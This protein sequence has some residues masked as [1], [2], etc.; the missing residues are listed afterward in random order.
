MSNS[1][2]NTYYN[3]NEKKFVD[4]DSE[5]R[6]ESLGNSIEIV[7]KVCSVCKAVGRWNVDKED[8]NFIVC[9]CGNEVENNE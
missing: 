7:N 2:T 1:H 9:E 5:I 8:K 4:I 3:R 6:A